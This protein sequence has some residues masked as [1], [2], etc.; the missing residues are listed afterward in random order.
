MKMVVVIL[1][2]LVFVPSPLV[3]AEE[4]EE[5]GEIKRY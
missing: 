5:L 2:S 3:T 4:E 1:L